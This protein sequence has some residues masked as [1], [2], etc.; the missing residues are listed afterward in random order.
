ML[1]VGVWDRRRDSS[2]RKILEGG[3]SGDG[4]LAGQ[5][6]KGI[7]QHFS[8]DPASSLPARIEVRLNRE[9]QL[10]AIKNPV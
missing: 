7:V 6:T 9:L 4:A 2:A 8:R 1:L 5:Q 10:A 3:A